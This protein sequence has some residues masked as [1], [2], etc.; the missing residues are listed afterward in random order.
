M[1]IITLGDNFRVYRMLLMICLGTCCTTVCYTFG[2]QSEWTL[3]NKKHRENKLCAT[4]TL[5]ILCVCSA[6]VTALRAT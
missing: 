4:C 2:L 6:V 3:F 1:M 5:M